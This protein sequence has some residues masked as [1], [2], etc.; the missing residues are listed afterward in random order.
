MLSVLQENAHGKVSLNE[1]LENMDLATL[2]KYLFEQRHVDYPI[3]INEQLSSKCLE[4][5]EK[6][7][8]VRLLKR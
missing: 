8:Y 5:L 6:K 1:T 2:E 3:I 4:E 7:K